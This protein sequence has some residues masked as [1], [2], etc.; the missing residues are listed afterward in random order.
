VWVAQQ[1]T[2]PELLLEPSSQ[3]GFIAVTFDL[4]Q[5]E[6]NSQQHPA[7]STQEQQGH[8]KKDP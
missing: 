1:P 3:P 5:N 2:P 4:S 7:T 8:C 6:A